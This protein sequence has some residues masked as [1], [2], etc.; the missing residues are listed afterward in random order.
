MTFK[1]G[2]SGNPKGR[3]RGPASLA[4]RI[5]RMVE[6]DAIEIVRSIIETAKTG[7]IEARR[8]FLKYLLPHPKVVMTPVDLP[9]AQ[10]A[11][12]AQE[13]I[14]MLV[15]MTAR[16]DLDLDSLAVLSRTLTLALSHQPFLLPTTWLTA[17]LGINKFNTLESRQD[18]AREAFL[19]RCDNAVLKNFER[20]VARP[21]V[22]DENV[23]IRS[24]LAQ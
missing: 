9:V 6:K 16:G 24:G 2:Q 11:A 4:V 5:R 17:G 20:P 14:S 18:P 10:S 22:A 7:D 3:P 12:E 1:P 23:E 15:Q 21:I 13:Q 19:A 8:Q